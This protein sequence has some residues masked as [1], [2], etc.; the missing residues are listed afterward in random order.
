MSCLINII[1]ID[2]DTLCFTVDT[3]YSVNLISLI[4]TLVLLSLILSIGDAFS[5]SMLQE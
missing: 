5:A 1:K 3:K 4:I 2:E